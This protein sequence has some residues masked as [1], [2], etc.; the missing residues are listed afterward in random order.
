MTEID[1]GAL[2][3]GS[4]AGGRGNGAAQAKAEPEFGAQLRE[5]FGFEGSLIRIELAERRSAKDTKDSPRARPTRR[6]RLKAKRKVA[7]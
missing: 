5:V 7:S 1:A 3:A 2:R 6:S 4:R